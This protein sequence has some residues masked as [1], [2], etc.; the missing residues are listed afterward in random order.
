MTQWIDSPT[1]L[2]YWWFIGTMRRGSQVF[3]IPLPRPMHVRTLCTTR[4]VSSGGGEPETTATGVAF[5]VKGPRGLG[6]LSEHCVGLWQ[7]IPEP[8]IPAQP[9]AQIARPTTPAAIQSAARRVEAML[10]KLDKTDT[11]SHD[12]Y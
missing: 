5:N 2:G 4:V 1:C 7:Y 9:M 10:A 11:D 8:A 3:D 12:G 6:F